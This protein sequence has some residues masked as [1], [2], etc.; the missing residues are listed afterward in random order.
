MNKNFKFRGDSEAKFDER[1]LK[2]FYQTFKEYLNS[3]KISRSFK[4]FMRPSFRGFLHNFDP[5]SFLKL[6][7]K[8]RSVNLKKTF[9]SINFLLEN[10]NYELN[11]KEQVQNKRNSDFTSPF[12]TK[13]LNFLSRDHSKT[14]YFRF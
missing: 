5:L 4:V 9:T 11:F 2:S 1:S 3:W 8:I 12:V 10:L 13:F 7:P 14:K 6:I